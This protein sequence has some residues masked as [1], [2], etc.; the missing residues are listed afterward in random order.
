MATADLDADGY[1]DLLVGAPYED[2]TGAQNRGSVTVLWGGSQGLKGGAL[3]STPSPSF[4][5][6]GCTFGTGLA[7]ANPKAA[8]G[9]A[10]VSVAG[11]CAS[12]RLAGPFTRTGKAT[13]SGLE[14]NTPSVDDTLLGDLNGDGRPEIVDI[15]VGLSDHPA[16]GIYVDPPTDRIPQPLPTDGDNAAIGDVNGDG[17]GDLV[18]GDPADTV[19][20]GSPQAGTGHQG[21]QIVIWPGGP[22]GVDP[23]ATPLL[24]HQSTPGV[25][26]SSESDDGFGSDV[27]VADT[28]GDGYAD[29]AV[30]V[31][32]EALGSKRNAG[33]VVLI[34]GGP[35]GPTG[36]GSRAISQ[37]TSGVPGT[38][39]RG[40][41]FGSTVRLV[42]L[43]RNDRPELVVGTPGE[44][45]DTGGLWVLKG[46][47]TGP[48]TTGS[49]SVMGTTVGLP[50]EHYTNWSSVQA[51]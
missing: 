38:A 43:N 13:A 47:T 39:E 3:L 35:Q 41:R 23:T 33:T 18:V 37:D 7:A 16:G 34:P 31:P 14:A 51:N 8:P 20:D 29:I 40:D 36:A 27:A 50:S 1:A 2:V 21:G 15:S 46:T 42:D 48:T 32:G 9:T 10:R 45:N 12:R 25:P 4:G 22:T 44:N 11:W 49:Y 28:N 19:I 30:G 5:G 17:Y 24:I 26:G 6:G